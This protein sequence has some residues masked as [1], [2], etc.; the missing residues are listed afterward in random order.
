MLFSNYTDFRLTLVDYLKRS[1]LDLEIARFIKMA[2]DR[3]NREIRHPDQIGAP[4]AIAMV[5]GVGALPADFIAFENLWDASGNKIEGVAKEISFGVYKD[6]FTYYVQDNS[7]YSG[8]VTGNLTADY[9]AKLPTLTT[10][11]TT[12]NWL[13]SKYPTVYLYGTLHQAF[14]FLRDRDNAQYYNDMAKGEIKTANI[15][16]YRKRFAGAVV[17]PQGI[18]R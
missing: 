13:L 17:V 2:E 1:D 18:E 7:I 9:Y 3:F 11:A 15:D 4:V 5:N 14:E 10:T 6:P 16:G 8:S 12:T